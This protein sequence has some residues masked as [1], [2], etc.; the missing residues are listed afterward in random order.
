MALTID[1]GRKEWE[2][3]PEAADAEARRRVAL[4]RDAADPADR[5]TIFLS[6]LAALTEIPPGL[7]AVRGLRRLIV[8]DAMGPDGRLYVVSRKIRTFAALVEATDLVELNL[9]DTGLA[10]LADLAGLSALHTL[11]LAGTQ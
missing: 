6:D 9:A 11:N 7:G 4:A 5:E 10:D 3:D 2:T 8:G 1:Y